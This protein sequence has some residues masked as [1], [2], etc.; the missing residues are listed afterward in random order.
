MVTWVEQKALGPLPLHEDER[1]HGVASFQRDDLEI[2]L[3]I[4]IGDRFAGCGLHFQPNLGKRVLGVKCDERRASYDA[5]LDH[6][7][8]IGGLDGRTG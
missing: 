3:A 2:D 4:Q 7:A 6:G 8:S 1:V 5:E